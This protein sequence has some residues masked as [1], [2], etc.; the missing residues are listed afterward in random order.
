M[1]IEGLT[2]GQVAMCDLLWNTDAPEALIRAMSPGDRM[3][4][5][6]MM[7]LILLSDIDDVVAKMPQQELNER[8]RN[9]FG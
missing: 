3:M 9:L 8:F 6:T 4:A 2:G 7:Q 1:I 5:R